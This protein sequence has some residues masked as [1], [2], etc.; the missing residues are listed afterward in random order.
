MLDKLLPDAAPEEPNRRGLVP[1]TVDQAV[2]II[3]RHERGRQGKAR[4]L[5]MRSLRMDLLKRGN[6]QPVRDPVS[7]ALTIQRVWRAFRTRRRAAQMAREELVFIGML[8]PSAGSGDAVERANAIAQARRQRREDNEVR[9]CAATAQRRAS[10][11]PV[12]RSS[13]T[14]RRW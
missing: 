3:Q 2:A 4:A 13:S 9:L 5:L 11:S 6:S 10:D 14:R 7:A 8:A 1:L 12:A